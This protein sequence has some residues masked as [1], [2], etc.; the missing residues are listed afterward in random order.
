MAIIVQ[1]NRSNPPGSWSV[2]KW[3]RCKASNTRNN[4]KCPL[5]RKSIEANVIAVAFICQ[6]SGYHGISS[7]KFNNNNN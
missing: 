6:Y 2:H 5:K 7:K 4:Q 1:D 3:A